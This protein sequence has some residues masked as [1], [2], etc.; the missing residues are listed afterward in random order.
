MEW[1]GVEGPGFIR[2]EKLFFLLQNWVQCNGFFEKHGIFVLEDI[3]CF[4]LLRTGDE[5]EMIDKLAEAVSTSH[6]S[7]PLLCI[8]LKRNKILNCQ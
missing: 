3:E 6:I 2:F 8:A 4:G 7:S 1:H 5:P